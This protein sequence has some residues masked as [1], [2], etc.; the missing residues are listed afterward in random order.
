MKINKEQIN[1][2]FRDVIDKDEQASLIP[3]RIVFSPLILGG[4]FLIL[5]TVIIA[6]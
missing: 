2:Y 4:A 6:L 1:Q 3:W 5:L